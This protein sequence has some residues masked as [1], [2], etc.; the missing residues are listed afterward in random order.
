MPLIVILG[1]LHN[2]KQLQISR[3]R[4]RHEKLKHTRKNRRKNDIWM[5]Y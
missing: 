4:N 3:L 5:I 2:F 1:N